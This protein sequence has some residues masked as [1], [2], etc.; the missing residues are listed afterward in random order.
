MA[1]INGK[2]DGEIPARKTVS[3]DLSKSLSSEPVFKALNL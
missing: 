1:F 3:N 2:I